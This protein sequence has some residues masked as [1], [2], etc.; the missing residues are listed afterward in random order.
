MSREKGIIRE[1]HL[2]IELRFKEII[3]IANFQ[4]KFKFI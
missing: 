2:K 4:L 1:Y 3:F